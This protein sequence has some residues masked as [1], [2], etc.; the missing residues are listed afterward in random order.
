MEMMDPLGSPATDEGVGRLEITYL[1]KKVSVLFPI[2]TS[3]V[4]LLLIS[5]QV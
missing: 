2:C 1:L 3:N 5:L 4:E